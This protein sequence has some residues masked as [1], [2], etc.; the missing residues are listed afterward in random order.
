MNKDLKYFVR[1]TEP[2]IVTM[3]GP[4][5]IKDDEG[6]VVQFKIKKLRQDEIEPIIEAYRKHS[7]A[8]D[9]KGSPLVINGEVVW[10]TERDNSKMMRHI[11]VEALQYPNLKDPDLMKH[12]GVVDVTEMPLKVF[13]TTEEYQYVANLVN[14]VLGYTASDE[15]DD[16]NAAKN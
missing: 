12:Y 5:T 2:E 11:I 9:K 4:D 15:D 16:L 14:K 8:T 7:V 1:N 10:K 13:P 6:N 3:P